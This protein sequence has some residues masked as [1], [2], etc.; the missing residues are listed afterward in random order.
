M[1]RPAAPAAQSAAPACAPGRVRRRR[2][3]SRWGDLDERPP[4][5]AGTH[6]RLHGDTTA[7]A[8]AASLTRSVL[9]NDVYSSSYRGRASGPAGG[10]HGSTACTAAPST[11]PRLP[12]AAAASCQCTAAAAVTLAAATVLRVTAMNGRAEPSGSARLCFSV[13]KSCIAKKSA[14]RMLS[15]SP[16]LARQTGRQHAQQ[17]AG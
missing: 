7:V 1:T 5:R 8:V 2:R 6:A 17:R 9:A 3:R 12:A 14:D 11:A 15:R 13:R 10:V 4:R 16:A